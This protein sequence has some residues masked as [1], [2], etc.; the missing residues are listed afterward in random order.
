MCGMFN[1]D[2]PNK[3]VLLG[4]TFVAELIHLPK[5]HR[6]IKFIY[7]KHIL[8]IYISRY[9]Y[10]RLFQTLSAISMHVRVANPLQAE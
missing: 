3:K 4:V 2:S 1:E 5:P 6:L 10:Y 9:I 7:I 8:S